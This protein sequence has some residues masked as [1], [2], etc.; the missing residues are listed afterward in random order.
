MNSVGWKKTFVQA[1]YLTS[2]QNETVS[3]SE[4]VRDLKPF[5]SHLLKLRQQQ[6]SGEFADEFNK[7]EVA[8][9]SY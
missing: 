8:Q 2:R 1:V 9:N 3:S 6:D 5:R 7:L 4:M